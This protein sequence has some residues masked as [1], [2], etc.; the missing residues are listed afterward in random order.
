MSSD[1]FLL[2]NGRFLKTKLHWLYD[3]EQKGSVL[4]S[5]FSVQ[6]LTSLNAKL[7]VEVL[8]T[9]DQ[10]TEDYG[11]LQQFQSNDRVYGGVEYVF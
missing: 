9:E 8:G 5:E 7:G 1:L 10:L 2:R 11:F 4:T 6:A 3:R